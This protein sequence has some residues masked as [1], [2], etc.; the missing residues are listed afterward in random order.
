MN[1]I[2]ISVIINFIAERKGDLMKNLVIV[3]SPAKAKTISKFLGSRFKVKASVGHV[4]DLP[5]SKMGIDFDDNYEPAYITIR[6]KGAIL[7]E[8]RMEAKKADKVYLATDPDREGEAISW[9]LSKALSIPENEACRVEFNEITKETIKNA[10]KHPRAINMDLVDAQQAR[11]ILD[12]IVG[13][14]ISPLLWR[15]LRKGLS[16]GRVQSVTT[17][18]IC[19]R[20]LEIKNFVSKEYWTLNATLQTEE[21]EILKASF[22]GTKEG[23]LPIDSEKEMDVILKSLKP[24]AYRVDSAETKVKK[25]SAYPPF[26]TSS[27]QQ[28]ASNKYGFS[29]KKTMMIAQ[30]LYEGIQVGKNI[31]GLVTY[32]RTDSTRISTVAQE[33]AKTF[34]IDNY[35]KEYL[36]PSKSAVKK[37]GKSIQDAHEA[38]R[39]TEVNLKPD[40]LKSQLKTEQYKLYKL[41]WERFLASQMSDSVSDAYQLEIVNSNYLFKSNGLKL[42]FDGFLK[43]Y[44]YAAVKDVEIPEIAAG[45][46]LSQIELEPKQNFT[47][48]PGRYTESTLVKALEENGIGRPSTYAP[49]I[50]TIISRGYVRREKK[51]LYPTEL[52]E[53]TNEI[54]ENYFKEIVDVDFTAKLEAELDQIETQGVE[55]KSVVDQFYTPFS[56]M[57]EVADKAIEKVDL[58]EESDEICEKCGSSMVVKHGR[59]GKFLA[60]SNY[61]ECDNTKSIVLKTGVACPKCGGDLVE[62]RTRKGRTFYGCANY[63][64][65]DFSTWDKPIK[66]HCPECDSMMVEKKSGKKLTV[67]CL[68][69]ACGYTKDTN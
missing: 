52:G 31:V 29:T 1:I 28:E 17:K 16:A 41:I 6:G 7:K 34:I 55:W 62:R 37:N 58:T 38:I 35:G 54:M 45:K 5:K 61:P 43:V 65:C 67:K 23:K 8:L 2:E 59:F 12:R 64:K 10:I 15:K 3:E 4:R 9:H 56:E 18:M 60:C 26:T 27:L 21:N 50:S 30:Q 32:I 13:Y 49:T 14:S 69:E 11:R 44:S 47:Q 40:D 42:K 46:V 39:P 51:I 66:D 36:K 53:M 33:A 20:E 22:Y 63:P 68:N 24:K 57:L 19:D 25:R 48:P